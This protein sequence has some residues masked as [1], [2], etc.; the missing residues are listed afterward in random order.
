MSGDIALA[1]RRSLFDGMTASSSLKAHEER[2]YEVAG[3]ARRWCRPP[4]AY[5]CDEYP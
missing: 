5:D 2:S 4:L 1:P 3:V